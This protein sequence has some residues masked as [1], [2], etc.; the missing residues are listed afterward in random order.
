M[1]FAKGDR[2]VFINDTQKGIVLDYDFGDE[3][4]VLCDDGFESVVAEKELIKDYSEDVPYVIDKD[5]IETVVSEK[6]LKPVRRIKVKKQQK[7]SPLEVDLHIEAIIETKLGLSNGDML[8]YQLNYAKQK[9]RHAN[10]NNIRRLVFIHGVGEGTLRQE[11]YKLLD[12]EGN[13]EYF[14]ASFQRYGSGATE[15]IVH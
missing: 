3:V 11:L 2:V 6:E 10:E 12:L 15:V 9:I 14:D 4:R 5:T 13:L 8:N 1:K 7:N